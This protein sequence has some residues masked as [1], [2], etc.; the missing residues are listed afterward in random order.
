MQSRPHFRLSFLCS[1]I[2]QRHIHTASLVTQRGL[3]NV[4]DVVR[5]RARSEADKLARHSVA[6]LPSETGVYDLRAATAQTLHKLTL[7]DQVLTPGLFHESSSTRTGS[8][9][10]SLARGQSHNAAVWNHRTTQPSPVLREDRLQIRQRRLELLFQFSD[11]G[12]E[13]MNVDD[14]I[15]DNPKLLQ[16]VLNRPR[17]VGATPQLCNGSQRLAGRTSRAMC[18]KIRWSIKVLDRHRVFRNRNRCW[19]IHDNAWIGPAGA[20]C[21]TV[22]VVL[23]CSISTTAAQFCSNERSAWRSVM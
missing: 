10:A 16:P 2:E 7:Q 1:D 8:T 5:A 14:R 4:L 21:R 15:G 20:V 22:F 12:I 23:V 13:L 11:L 9:D 19:N 17:H 6:L 3:Q 18:R